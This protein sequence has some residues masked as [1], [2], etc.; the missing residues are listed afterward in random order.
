M[1]LALVAPAGLLKCNQGTVPT[2]FMIVGRTVLAEG[3]LMGNITDIVPLVNIV[4]FG[5][6]AILAAIG[7]PAC[8]PVIVTPWISKAI[9]VLVEG[10]P[11]IDYSAFLLCA[12]GGKISILEPGNVTVMVP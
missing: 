3:M 12:V 6:C 4:P 10:R 7:D 9:N 8:T 2:P 1:S 11:A 5:N